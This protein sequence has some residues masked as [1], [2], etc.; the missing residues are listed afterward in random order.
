MQVLKPNTYVPQ[1][2][3]F[4]MMQITEKQLD[5]VE[6][7]LRLAQWAIDDQEPS[8]QRTSDQED[9]TDAYKAI[10]DVRF[11]HE[12]LTGGSDE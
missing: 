7:A 1:D 5:A 2:Q 11:L 6:W 10:A 12:Q 8:D 9:I 4:Q 3:Q